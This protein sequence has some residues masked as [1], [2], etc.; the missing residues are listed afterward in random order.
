[1]SVNS[2]RASSHIVLRGSR[3]GREKRRREGT[4][5]ST[6]KPKGAEDGGAARSEWWEGEVNKKNDRA[7]GQTMSE[8]R[9]GEKRG[10]QGMNGEGS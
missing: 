6:G 9:G 5:M 3:R 4:R 7:G 8:R 2:A 1:M 10:G